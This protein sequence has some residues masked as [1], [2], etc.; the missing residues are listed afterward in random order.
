MGAKWTGALCAL[1]RARPL[2]SFLLLLWPP[3]PS[4]F[5]RNSIQLYSATIGSERSAPLIGPC[6]RP[7]DT[8][9]C[10]KPEAAESR[11]WFQFAAKSFVFCKLLSR[12][13]PLQLVLLW[14]VDVLLLRLLP[15]ALNCLHKPAARHQLARNSLRNQQHE[16]RSPNRR[17]SLPLRWQS[18]FSTFSSRSHS[19]NSVCVPLASYKL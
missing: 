14:P 10:W 4:V 3:Q 8:C 11:R 16:I 13:L 18:F 12:A 1:L 7:D 2:S 9:C 19:L 5:E 17:A 15:K 6:W